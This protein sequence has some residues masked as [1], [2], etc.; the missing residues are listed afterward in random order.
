MKKRLDKKIHK[1]WLEM[2][3]IDA[4]QKSYWRKKLFEA[5]YHQAFPID[6]NHLESI[7]PDVA[8]AIKKYNLRYL[9]A[10]VPADEAEPWLSEGGL[11]IF[12][13]WAINHPSVKMF[14]GNNPDVI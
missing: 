6:K 14:S 1:K 8:K 9:V 5:E 4:S 12:K 10:K 7:L 2:G 13:F 3:V 11:I